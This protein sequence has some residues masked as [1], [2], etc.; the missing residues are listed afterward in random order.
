MAFQQ[1]LQKPTDSSKDVCA[2]ASKGDFA[3]ALMVDRA[4]SPHL[5]QTASR[6]TESDSGCGETNHQVILQSNADMAYC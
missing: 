1:T 3:V 6:T 5:L 4:H 2:A